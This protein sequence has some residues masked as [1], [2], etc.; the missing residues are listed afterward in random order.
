MTHNATHT[1]AV[2]DPESGSVTV[3]NPPKF[4]LL[5]LGLVGMLLLVGIGRVA[6]EQVD[7]YFAAVLFYGLGNGIAAVK[8]QPSQPV[9]G[10]KPPDGD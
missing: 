1:T 8:G 4:Y 2:P 6:W 5:A 3:N 10:R 7:M 9:F